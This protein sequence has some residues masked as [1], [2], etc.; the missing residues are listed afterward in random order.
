MTKAVVLY[1][2]EEKGGQRKNN[3][4]LCRRARHRSS[5]SA[6]PSSDAMIPPLCVRPLTRLR[7][8][9]ICVTLRS[10][11]APSTTLDWKGT[12]A[13]CSFRFQLFVLLVE[14]VHFAMIGG[15]SMNRGGEGSS[16]VG[17]IGIG[18]T[19]LLSFCVVG[20]GGRR[21]RRYGTDGIVFG[22]GATLAALGG[23]AGGKSVGAD[24][25]IFACVEKVV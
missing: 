15:G 19:H 11:D 7:A 1:T 20:A 4:K 12:F 10:P 8:I 18:S 14:D 22:A 24:Y 9:L 3:E 25:C 2:R 16:G 17:G 21:A 23:C 5:G 13:R 6:C